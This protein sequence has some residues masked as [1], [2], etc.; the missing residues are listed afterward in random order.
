LQQVA[1][2]LSMQ[3]SAAS[4]ERSAR[5]ELMAAQRRVMVLAQVDSHVFDTDDL[6]SVEFAGCL[7]ELCARLSRASGTEGRLS[8]EVVATSEEISREQAISL[9]LVASEL[10]TNALVH[11]YPGTHTTGPVTVSFSENAGQL[12]LV[13]ADRGRG[14]PA[15]IDFRRPARFGGRLIA[16]LTSHMR[17]SLSVDPG[18]PGATISVEVPINVPTPRK[19]VVVERTG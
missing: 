3:A 11:A 12:R 18:P 1:S 7:R 17:G 5:D 9:A 6:S 19:P 2:L 14:L 10:V 8:I 13:V 4:P 15:G 16:A